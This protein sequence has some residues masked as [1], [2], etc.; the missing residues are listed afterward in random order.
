MGSWNKKNPGNSKGNM[1]KVWTL[2]NNNVAILVHSLWQMHPSKVLTAAR[3]VRRHTESL[4]N[5]L[6]LQ[7]SFPVFSYVD[8]FLL[9]MSL[10][11]S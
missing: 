6:S 2:V 1:N 7:D 9:G 5:A 3:T 10:F 4:A 11:Q 8:I